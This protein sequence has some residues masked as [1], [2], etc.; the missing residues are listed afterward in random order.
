MNWICISL[1]GNLNTSGGNL[2]TKNYFYWNIW[3]CSQQKFHSLIEQLA[4][5]QPW[6][7]GFA[8]FSP[9]QLYFSNLRNFVRKRII[10]LLIEIQ[11]LLGFTNL[12]IYSTDLEIKE[13]ALIVLPPTCYFCYLER[14]DD[15]ELNL[16]RLNYPQ[17]FR[18]TIQKTTIIN[19]YQHAYTT[20]KEIF[21]QADLQLWHNF[22]TSVNFF[23]YPEDRYEHSDQSPY[24]LNWW[25]ERIVKAIKNYNGW[26]NI[27]NF[28]DIW[29]LSSSFYYEPFFFLQESIEQPLD[30][31]WLICFFWSRTLFFHDLVTQDK[32]T[33]QLWTQY[34]TIP[35]R[36]WNSAELK[37]ALNVIMWLLEYRQNS[38]LSYYATAK[39]YQTF[40]F[41]KDFM[42]IWN[43]WVGPQVRSTVF[44]WR[45]WF[46]NF[47]FLWNQLLT[48]K[49][50]LASS[51]LRTQDPYGAFYSWTLE[52][53]FFPDL[54]FWIATYL[55]TYFDE[56]GEW[57]PR[58]FHVGASYIDERLILELT[59]YH[60][61]HNFFGFFWAFTVDAFQYLPVYMPTEGTQI[62]VAVIFLLSKTSYAEFEDMWCRLNDYNNFFHFWQQ[63]NYKNVT[64]KAFYDLPPQGRLAKVWD[65]VPVNLRPLATEKVIN[66]LFGYNTSRTNV[67][68]PRWFPN[69]MGNWKFYH[70][71]HF[72]SVENWW[73]EAAYDKLM[74]SLSG[75]DYTYVSK[76]PSY[77]FVP[78]TPL[79]TT[80]SSF[81]QY[82]NTNIFDDFGHFLTTFTWENSRATARLPTFA[83]LFHYPL[84]SVECIPDTHYTWKISIFN[85]ELLN[86]DF[87]AFGGSTTNLPLRQTVYEYIS[88]GLY[89]YPWP[90]DGYASETRIIY[91]R[92]PEYSLAF[93]LQI[94]LWLFFSLAQILFPN[95]WISKII[96]LWNFSSLGIPKIFYLS[97]DYILNL[98]DLCSQKIKLLFQLTNITHYLTKIVQFLHYYGD[99]IPCSGW[100]IHCW[101]MFFFY[102]FISVKAHIYSLE[103]KQSVVVILDQVEIHYQMLPLEFFLPV[104]PY[105]RN[106]WLEIRISES[107]TTTFRFFDTIGLQ[108][109]N[110][111]EDYLLL[112]SLVDLLNRDYE[113]R[114]FKNYVVV[115]NRLDMQFLKLNSLE[116]QRFINYI[117]KPGTYVSTML[118]KELKV[119]NGE[120]R[121]DDAA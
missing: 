2:T 58:F 96:D 104:A 102:E 107:V 82:L 85:R 43:Y 64:A 116:Y 3:P 91:A 83:W 8:L 108:N 101:K 99:F 110:D 78:V 72:D 18:K 23:S 31:F 65:S 29:L 13:P 77:F 21:F 80:I 75:Y 105:H 30:E 7:S 48:P 121:A 47:G 46:G 71:L 120:L 44:S 66:S 49:V 56:F 27:W 89:L 22:M 73:F 12:L 54:I 68:Q 53:I 42:L 94:D 37:T 28:L 57:Y 100:F 113:V 103:L 61:T 98:L 115:F 62:R 79:V 92:Y 25:F 114:F 41:D 90:L 26:F 45:G 74:F 1:N 20:S 97:E 111:L 6:S 4:D 81:K 112:W 38:P 19:P 84:I 88:H 15:A 59:R 16:L 10:N 69:F 39:D 67:N 35:D 87:Y 52:S 9:D 24:L 63:K 109:F 5:L 40:A 33:Q 34:L 51:I 119:D 14:F 17:P 118:T 76:M 95:S 93:G 32:K 86:W 11:K 50:F 117:V 55:N 36:L 70:Q 60:F 106:H